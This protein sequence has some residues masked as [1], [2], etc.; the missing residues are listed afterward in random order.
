MFSLWMVQVKKFFQSRKS[1]RAM[2]VVVIGS[3]VPSYGAG[4]SLSSSTGNANVPVPLKLSLMV[5]AR[6]YVLGKLVKPKF[7][8]KVDCP[9]VLEPTKLNNPVSL[10]NSCQY[11]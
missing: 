4:S 7:Y 10:K 1:Q 9:V 11:S 5:T 8:I 6:A 3:E 2:N